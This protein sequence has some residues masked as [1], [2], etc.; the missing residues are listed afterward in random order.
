M[1]KGREICREN[2]IKLSDVTFER[3][4]YNGIPNKFEAGTGSIADAV[5]LG[6]ALQYLSEIGMPCV[7]RWEHE[8]LQYGLKELKTVKG[9]HLVGTALNKASALAFSPSFAGEAIPNTILT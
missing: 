2:E 7:F 5:G 8:L 1:R 4:I 3:T 9:L 6:A